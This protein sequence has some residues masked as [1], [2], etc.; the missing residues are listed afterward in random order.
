MSLNTHL[1]STRMQY[2]HP[3]RLLFVTAISVIVFNS[4]KK[5]PNNEIK[6]AWAINGTKLFYDRYT[7]TDTIKNSLTFTIIDNVFTGQAKPSIILNVLDRK[8]KIKKGG[9]FGIACDDCSMSNFFSCLTTFDF[10][11][12]PNSATLN[13]KLP[14]YSCGKDANYVNEVVE[15]DKTITVPQGTYKTFVL[16]SDNGD[17]SYWNADYGLIMYETIRNNEKIIYKLT[18]TSVL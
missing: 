15:I 2:F 6:Y 10:L 5:D 7:Q 12:L 4:C 17:L 9:L 14:L 13:Q 1:R 3:L 18:K 16:K 11:Y 8:F